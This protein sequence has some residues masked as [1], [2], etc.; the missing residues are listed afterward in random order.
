MRLQDII[1]M[2]IVKARVVNAGSKLRL[3]RVTRQ[4]ILIIKER[5]NSIVMQ[6]LAA[7]QQH[8]MW[9]RLAHQHHLPANSIYLATPN[10]ILAPVQMFQRALQGQKHSVQAR[11]LLLLSQHIVLYVHHTPALILQVQ[12]V[13]L[14]QHL[15]VIMMVIPIQMIFVFNAPK[16]LI[17]EY[18]RP[19]ILQ[20]TL[21]RMHPREQILK[22][23]A[24]GDLLVEAHWLTAMRKQ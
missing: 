14:R 20:H 13:A 8:F 4:Q 11:C 6:V 18:A 19:A 15:I 7:L 21:A 5:I 24:Q 23:N 17:A 12:Q 3:R 22:M 1:M 16:I 2:E 9:T 10:V